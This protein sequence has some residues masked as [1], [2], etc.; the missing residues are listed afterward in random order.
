[1]NRSHL[2]HRTING[3]ATLV[4]AIV[5][6][7]CACTSQFRLSSAELE[8]PRDRTAPMHVIENLAIA[9]RD[10]NLE[11]YSQQLHPNLV[12][13]LGGRFDEA[14]SKQPGSD[15]DKEIAGAKH[16][17]GLASAIT[18]TFDCAAPMPSRRAGYP[19][20]GG[21]LEVRVRQLRMEITPADPRFAPMVVKD[22]TVYV[23]GHDP[24]AANLWMIVAESTGSATAFGSPVD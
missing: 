22:S 9:Y 18:C 23:L 5:G 1:M 11:L 17:F 21:Y 19:A 16:I 3:I 12:V 4:V 8:G 7:G 13:T 2:A 15:R 10:R 24:N 14:R 20:S 6:I